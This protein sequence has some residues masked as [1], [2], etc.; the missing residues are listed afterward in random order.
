MPAMDSEDLLER[1]P[2]LRATG[3]CPKE[4]ARAFGL[5]LA[6]LPPLV[7]TIAAEDHAGASER[8]VTGCWV[9]P[10]WSHG[11]TVEGHPGWPDVDAADAEALGQVSVLVTRQK[12]YGR[13]RLCC[14]LVDVYRLEIKD[15]GRPAR[16]GRAPRGRLP[17]LV[18]RRLPG[19]TARDAAGVGAASGVRRGRVRA[20]LGF[21]P[22]RALRRPTT[23]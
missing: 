19:Q 10:G 5:R 20:G 9:S 17:W 3:R 12:G 14:W 4:I 1:V 8:K 23:N 6:Q 15:L 16:H 7:R 22:V 18:L 13:V 2:A 11:R 21:E